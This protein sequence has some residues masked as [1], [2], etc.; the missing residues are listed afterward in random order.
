MKT[1]MK[2]LT[3]AVLAVGLAAGLQGCATLKA[4]KV[5]LNAEQVFRQQLEVL[6]VQGLTEN[7]SCPKMCLELKKAAAAKLGVPVQ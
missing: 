3:L 7:W 4:G 1:T 2:F 6:V 5:A